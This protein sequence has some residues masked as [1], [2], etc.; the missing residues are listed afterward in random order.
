MTPLR[1]RMS[2][3]MLQRGLS[4]CTRDS[5][6]GAI[7]RMARYYRRDPAEY[8]AAEVQA[9]LLHMVRDRHLAYSTMNVTACAFR[10]LYETVLNHEREMFHIPMAKVPAVQ[11]ELLSRNELSRLFAAC[12]SPVHRM[13]L[14]TMYATGLRVSEACALRVKDIDSAPDRMCIRVEHGKGGHTRYTL[15]P[16]TLLAYLRAYV[17]GT[18]SRD[19]LFCNQRNAQAVSVSTAQAAYYGARFRAGITKSG[20]IHTLRHD[21]ATHLLEGGIDLFTIQKLMGH[22]HIGT[23]SRYLRLISPQFRPPKNVDPLDLLAGLPML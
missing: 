13:L 6:I 17:R 22:G 15:L 5:Y 9:Y 12:S 16:V 7:Y 10:F 20:G 4:A 3:A 19:W 11:P 14:Q 1:Q 18:T 2:D 23:T 21:F 8:T